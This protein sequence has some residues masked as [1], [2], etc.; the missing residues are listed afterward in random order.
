MDYLQK[1]VLEQPMPLDMRVENLT[2]PAGLDAVIQRALA[3][4]RE[5]GYATANEFAE[6]RRP[7]AEPFSSRQPGRP[8]SVPQPF[9]APP[10]FA[11]GRFL[12][13]ALVA[14]VFFLVGVAMTA[15]ALR[16]VGR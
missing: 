9:G 1:H 7:Y 15:V 12:R 5:D 10:A 3:K 4:R 6:A 16:F 8:P 13:S 11:Q 14:A 2:F